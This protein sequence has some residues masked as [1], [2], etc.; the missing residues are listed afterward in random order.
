MI[1]NHTI[2][3]SYSLSLSLFPFPSLAL[4]TSLVP[5]PPEFITSL[6][7]AIKSTAYQNKN[8][9]KKKGGGNE[10]E[11]GKGERGRYHLFLYTVQP[12]LF[13]HVGVAHPPWHLIR[14]SLSKKIISLKNKNIKGGRGEK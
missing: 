2:K 5:S 11:N 1:P 7:Y 6:K 4:L 8:K 14:R 9:N 3:L 10:G 12:A 13:S